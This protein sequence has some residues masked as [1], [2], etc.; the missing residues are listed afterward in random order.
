MYVL[1][2]DMGILILYVL[3]ICIMNGIYSYGVGSIVVR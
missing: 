1:K 3:N 2:N